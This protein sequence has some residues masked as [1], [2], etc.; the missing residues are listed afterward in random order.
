[1]K[2]EHHCPYCNKHWACQDLD[3]IEE[4][5]DELTC[6]LCQYDL[7]DEEHAEEEDA[8]DSLPEV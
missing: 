3:C 6:H 2:H 8:N 1:M 5:N 4:A 7:R